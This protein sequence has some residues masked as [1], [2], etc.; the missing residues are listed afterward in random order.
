DAGRGDD[1]R[2]RHAALLAWRERRR[3]PGADAGALAAIDQAASH[4]R[5]R[6]GAG[7]GRGQPSRVP[8]S[9]LESERSSASRAD[10]ATAAG[11]ILIHAFPDRIARQDANNPRR[12]ALSN[13]RGARLHEQSLLYGEPWLVV[14][15]LRYEERDS[16]ILS[17]APFD[18]VLLERDFPQ[19][20]K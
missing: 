9:R 13:G 15:D 10:A 12:Y 3:A 1:F 16:L 17:A 20:F 7:S 14:L 6:F 18:P 2:Q 4:W 11:D 19:R 5:R 8:G